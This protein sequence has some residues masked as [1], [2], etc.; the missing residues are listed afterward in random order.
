MIVTLSARS[1]R[2][3]RRRTTSDP[4][5]RAARCG[6]RYSLSVIHEA[7]ESIEAV[8]FVEILVMRSSGMFWST[9]C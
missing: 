9:H 1:P 3:S 8:V 4:A 2:S 5:G 6:P 7:A